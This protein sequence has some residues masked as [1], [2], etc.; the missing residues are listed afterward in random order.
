[1]ENNN[2]SMQ[3]FD[4]SLAKELFEKSSSLY[5]SLMFQKNQFI[6]PIT[7]CKDRDSAM[8]R[9]RNSSYGIDGKVTSFNQMNEDKIFEK[10]L[11]QINK[12]L[13]N[14]L[15]MNRYLYH[16]ELIKKG[17]KQLSIIKNDIVK[18]IDKT[19]NKNNFD[20]FISNLK[21][22]MERIEK[23][24]NIIGYINSAKEPLETESRYSI[25]SND[26]IGYLFNFKK[27]VNQQLISLIMLYV[28]L[29][30]GESF[31]LSNVSIKKVKVSVD[32]GEHYSP[33]KPSYCD[34]YH[35]ALTF[36]T[37]SYYDYLIK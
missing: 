2:I 29:K 30:F 5:N 24:Y 9:E 27:S 8:Y 18:L 4:I 16:N 14:I 25:D 7:I 15:E 11:P 26:N 31:E 20:L 21:K 22:E 17:S 3:D 12:Y 6:G 34:Q 13:K 19:G 36:K 32:I 28:L 23:N 1:M 33:I 35:L 10:K 37:G